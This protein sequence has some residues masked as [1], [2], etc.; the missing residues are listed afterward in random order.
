MALWVAQGI[1]FERVVLQHRPMT[2]PKNSIR[3]QEA[4]EKVAEVELHRFGEGALSPCVDRVVCE[5]P[6]EIQVNGRSIALVMRTPGDDYEL[7]TGFL[8]TEQI[9]ANAEDILSLRHCTE[10]PDPEAVD[11]IVRVRLK[12]GVEVDFE[13][14]SRHFFGS[15]SCGVCGKASIEQLRLTLPVLSSGPLIPAALIPE[16][17]QRMEPTQEVFKQTGG[18]HGAALFAS[19]GEH[20][21]TRED[22]G[23]HNAVDK[24]IGGACRQPLTPLGESVLAV[25]GRVSFEIVQKALMVGIPMIV[26]VSAPSSL[27]IALAREHGLTLLGFTRGERFNLYSGAERLICGEKDMGVEPVMASL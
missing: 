3:S 13:K 18:L 11:N 17:M 20:I 12:P 27:A 8:V 15:S 2:T 10:A 5:E 1:A 16:M 25:S 21:I 4:S 24:V 23:R 9:V 26:A 14:L 22:V 6:L 19:S 7:V